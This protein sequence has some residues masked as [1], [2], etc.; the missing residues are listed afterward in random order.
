[1]LSAGGGGL[2]AGGPF[3]GLCNPQPWTGELIA[4]ATDLQLVLRGPN[5]D[6]QIFLPFV[7][8]QT[9]RLHLLEM[10]RVSKIRMETLG[11]FVL[12]SKTSRNEQE[13]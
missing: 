8:Y 3:W 1:M 10:C 12:Q 11:I 5:H 6:V 9:E 13:F 7:F 2:S 4:S